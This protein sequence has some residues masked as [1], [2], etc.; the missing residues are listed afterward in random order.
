[1]CLLQVYLILFLDINNSLEKKNF[2]KGKDEK[3]KSFHEDVN[4]FMYNYQLNG[5]FI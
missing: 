1:M 5:G 4:R 3:Q 2:P